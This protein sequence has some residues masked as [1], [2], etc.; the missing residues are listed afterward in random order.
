MGW[1]TRARGGRYYT[2]SRR[3]NGRV[4]REYIGAGS[5]GELAAREDAQRR[6]ARE[7]ERAALWAA[8]DR[9]RAIDAELTGV[10]RIVDQLTRGALLAAGYERSKRQ[11]RLRREQ[12]HRAGEA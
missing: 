9:A 10:H 3:E 6:A 2:R 11:W 12:I 1:E 4:V 5:A 7:A 8:R